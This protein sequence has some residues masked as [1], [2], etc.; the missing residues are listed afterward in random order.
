M[1]RAAM[2][3]ICSSS[4]ARPM[5][6][7]RTSSSL[8]RLAGSTRCVKERWTTAVRS[9]QLPPCSLRW[10]SWVPNCRHPAS[11]PP[12]QCSPLRETAAL[13]L[14]LQPPVAPLLLVG[15]GVSRDS[16]EVHCRSTI[17]TRSGMRPRS[18]STKLFFHDPGYALD[19]LVESPWPL[20]ELLALAASLRSARANASEPVRSLAGGDAIPSSSKGSA[21]APAATAPAAAGVCSCD[22]GAWTGREA[23]A[24]AAATRALERLTEAG[25]DADR[26]FE[27]ALSADAAIACEGQ[28][29]V[30]LV[31]AKAVV[32]LVFGF[33][34]E[35]DKDESW[36]LA[37]QLRD[38]GPED[39]D[40]DVC[41]PGV[42]TLCLVCLPRELALR[43]PSRSADGAQVLSSPLRLLSVCVQPGDQPVEQHLQF[44]TDWSQLTP[45]LWDPDNF[46]KFMLGPAFKSN[47]WW[48]RHRISE[49]MPP[50]ANSDGVV[51]DAMA[52]SSSRRPIPAQG[53]S[54]C[55]GVWGAG[56][57]HACHR[58]TRGSGSSSEAE[59]GSRPL[60]V[61]PAG[62]V[63]R[64]RALGVGPMK[65]GSTV[66]WQA[67]GAA[68][69]LSMGMDCE[70]FSSGTSFVH[71]VARREA[72]LEHF[73]DLCYGELFHWDLA[74]DPMATTLSRRLAD[75]WPSLSSHG[76]P[77][78][79]YFVIRNPFDC[80][81]SLLERLKV[82]AL[83]ASPQEQR[84]AFASN[85]LPSRFTGSMQDYLD[86]AR[87]GLE[88]S[89]FVD[90]A[91]QR[92]ALIVDE[93]LRCPSRFALVRYEDFT[94]DP[95]AET[96]RLAEMLNLTAHWGQGSEERVKEAPDPAEVL[97]RHHQLL[98][99]CAITT[100]G[101]LDAVPGAR[102]G[103]GP[104]A[105]GGLRRGHGR[106]HL[107][108]RGRPRR[109]PWLRP[110]RRGHHEG[111]RAW[112]AAH[113]C[114][115]APG[116]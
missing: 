90:A 57:S 116:D 49:D 58:A 96:R 109:A 84:F 67:L 112:V 7:T 9:W 81:R 100:S 25:S 41:L 38:L 61:P 21:S 103:P 10:P 108:G 29:D 14:P 39:W 32:K 34:S 88:Y 101:C 66:I 2:R 63:P 24:V 82:K 12:L 102:Q 83:V 44:V 47:R 3:S 1:C 27:A 56:P 79:L 55:S 68:T 65:A 30:R 42:V 62:G 64:T 76:G 113:R 73:I 80:A 11:R 20:T 13:L 8:C 40:A 18:P 86:V 70:L 51:V 98:S 92:W 72:P 52:L 85:Q 60:E 50:E 89:G 99:E 43:R 77:L 37:R 36:E 23:R 87:D 5:V 91:V 15:A 35:G 46:F 53:F 59:S 93:Y 31:K 104:R 16:A 106:P 115:A 78:Q 45:W 22:L 95:V 114:A 19:M 17:W 94:K 74:K 54:A 26:I 28:W 71:R 105:R 107:D 75:A 110:Q 33:D 48:G 111:C 6:S 4:T 69:Q 97:Q